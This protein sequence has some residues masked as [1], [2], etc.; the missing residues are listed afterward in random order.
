MQTMS[1]FTIQRMGVWMPCQRGL[2]LRVAARFVSCMQ[3]FHSHIQVRKGAVIAN[4]K[5]ILDLLCLGATWRSKLEIEAIGEDAAQ[6]LKSIK[7]F[8][9][10]ENVNVDQS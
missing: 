3:K 4:A 8:F 9:D 5:S 1:S 10:K 6:A 2:H 7:E